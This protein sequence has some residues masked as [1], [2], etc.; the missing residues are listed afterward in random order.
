MFKFRGQRKDNGEWEVGM[1]DCLYSSGDE[2][3]YV[4][5]NG[6]EIHPSSLSISFGKLDSNKQEIFASFEIDGKMT[7]GGDVLS[8]GVSVDSFDAYYDKQ[9]ATFYL[10]KRLTTKFWEHGL[11][12][13]SAKFTIIGKGGGNDK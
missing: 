5:V 3:K 8:N 9:Y 12:N 6:H 4:T 13:E 7:R 1:L 11:M 2:F 10:R